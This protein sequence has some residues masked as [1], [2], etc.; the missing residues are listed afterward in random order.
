[1]QTVKSIPLI[2]FRV[3]VA[4]SMLALFF[5]GCATATRIPLD[6]V[7]KETF[8]A[9]NAIA[10]FSQN[11]LDAEVREAQF[12]AATSGGLFDIIGENRHAEK[13]DQDLEPLR[14]ALVSFDFNHEVKT[15]LLEAF[16]GSPT[17]LALSKIEI[18]QSTDLKANRARLAA[19]DRAKPLLI[20][21]LY[22][23]LNRDY[24]SLAITC[25][26]SLYSARAGTS[27]RTT[28]LYRNFLGA[29]QFTPKTSEVSVD[30]AANV[31]IWSAHNASQARQALQ[32]A[33]KEIARLLAYDLIFPALPEGKRLYDETA[34]GKI[35]LPPLY[36][37]WRQPWQEGRMERFESGRKWVRMPTGELF[38]IK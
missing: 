38:S 14:G 9:V 24:S 4:L 6:A 21:S 18:I 32:A 20:L 33:A 17:N 13:V 29:F 34:T 25:D 36:P 11:E 8:G 37:L 7:K 27:N 2:R 15:S 12:V 30:P 1:M 31:A 19:A 3:T 26:A 35:I 5:G 22:Y 28:L 10:V 23:T 16:S